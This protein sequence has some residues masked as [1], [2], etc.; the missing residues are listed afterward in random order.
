[1]ET[2]KCVVD[3]RVFLL[4]LDYLYR[5]AVKKFERSELLSCARR[6][7]KTLDVEPADVPIEGYYTEDS[8][9]TQRS[10]MTGYK[11]SVFSESLRH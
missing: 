8:L 2:V 10:S 9:W 1:M 5:E 7:S 3:D 11:L 4:G 6:I